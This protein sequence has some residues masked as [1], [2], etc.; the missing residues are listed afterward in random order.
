M[1]HPPTNLSRILERGKATLDRAI[2]MIF[3]L[4]TIEVVKR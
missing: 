4:P 3:P 2:G 1:H